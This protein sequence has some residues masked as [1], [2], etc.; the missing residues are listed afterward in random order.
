MSETTWKKVNNFWTR[1]VEN[2]FVQS[3]Y[4]MIDDYLDTTPQGQ[5]TIKK[6]V[7]DMEMRKDFYF[8]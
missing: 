5:N 8:E 3:G 6:I 2:Q 7:N 4:G 1:N